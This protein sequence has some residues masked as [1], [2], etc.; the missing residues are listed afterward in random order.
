MIVLT[1]PGVSHFFN[2]VQHVVLWVVPG[3]R[4]V[5]HGSSII[6]IIHGYLNC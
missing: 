3:N 6:I 5:I 4:R 2:T 1:T